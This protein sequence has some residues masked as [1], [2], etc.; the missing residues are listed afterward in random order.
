MNEQPIF[1]R[2]SKY[3]GA[4]LLPVG[5]LVLWIVAGSLYSQTH[6]RGAKTMAEQ[7]A[8]L[9][10]T[11]LIRQIQ[12]AD[13]LVVTNPVGPPYEKGFSLKI[14]GQQLKNIINAVSS[15]RVPRLSPPTNAACDWE[16]RFYRGTNFLD[17]ARFQ[18]NVLRYDRDYID[19]TGVL[20]KLYMSILKK[21][22]PRRL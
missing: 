12:F 19:Q 15:A 22:M 21:T 8:Y 7:Y 17:V 9:A 3:R 13:I 11:N 2:R 1:R 14:S 5:L 16:L 6:D 20:N 18:E 4:V 10:P